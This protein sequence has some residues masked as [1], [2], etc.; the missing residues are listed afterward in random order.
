MKGDSRRFGGREREIDMDTRRSVSNIDILLGER[1]RNKSAESFLLH[2]RHGR[3]ILHRQ[4]LDGLNYPTSPS[5]P[6]TSSSSSSLS[7]PRSSPTLS[8]LPPSVHHPQDS[9]WVTTHSTL[10]IRH[11]AKLSATDFKITCPTTCPPLKI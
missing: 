9:V 5:S 11:L 4:T 7:P 1:V 10:R 6:S 2:S 8:S 3:P